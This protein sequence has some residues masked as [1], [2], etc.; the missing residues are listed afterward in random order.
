MYSNRNTLGSRVS[1]TLSNAGEAKPASRKRPLFKRP[2]TWLVLVLLMIATV[3]FAMHWVLVGRFLE[4]TNDAYI[5]ADQV[6]VAP[7]VSG[8][9]RKVLV[10]DNQAVDAGQPL[11]EIDPE[12]YKAVLA[13]Q[14][15]TFDA[16]KA[17]IVAAEAQVKQQLAMVDEAR[18]KL[19][20]S[21]VGA[22]FAAKEV[23]R[24]RA[25]NRNGA[26]TAEK[27]AQVMNTKDEADST[28]R[29]DSAALAAAQR[30]SDTLRAQIGQAEAQAEAA[31]ASA[32][33]AGLDVE[34]T[35][36]RASI[37]GRVGDR[38]VRTGQFVQPG[39]RM[40]SIVPVR[41]LYVVAN[42]KETQIADMKIGQP[43]TVRID[44]LGGRNIRGVLESFAPGTGA[45][46]AMLPPEN[47][48]GNFTKI[49]QRVPVRFRI[50]VDD[51]TRAR[52]LPGLSVTVEINTSDPVT[53][54]IATDGVR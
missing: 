48:T 47:A 27:L 39:T 54:P 31:D 17:D 45:Q 35:L 2:L 19:A 4:S 37:A 9:V 6:S 8:Y 29:T 15:G 13:R 14:R 12:N 16:R 51:D 52:L 18:A 1:T 38:T 43:A 36:V 25:L 22:R 34:N 20:G 28:V 33:E 11:V 3:L 23:D 49:V 42:F 44:A 50:E 24:Y 26:E 10:E 46:F 7:K 40:L 30:Q 41:S 21:Q 53:M 5:M 32:Q